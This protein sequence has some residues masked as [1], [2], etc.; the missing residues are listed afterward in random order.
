MRL[1]AQIKRL[2]L[3]QEPLL[4]DKGGEGFMF[5]GGKWF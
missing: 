2:F 1:R 3:K 5:G 4:G